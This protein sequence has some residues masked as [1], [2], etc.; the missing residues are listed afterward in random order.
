[1]SSHY[2]K[3]LLEQWQQH[4]VQHENL[5]DITISMSQQDAVR[6]QALADIFHMEQEHI[7][8]DLL[9]QSLK[10]VEATIPYQAGANVIRVEE[11]EPI[12]ED[13]GLMPAYLERRQDLRFN[14]QH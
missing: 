8:A 7:I 14:S 5:C 11:G 12:Y 3:N 9:A 13:I 10:E 2:L 6:I 4:A 1:M